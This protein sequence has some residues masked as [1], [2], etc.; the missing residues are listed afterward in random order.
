MGTAARF[1]DGST[2]RLTTDECQLSSARRS[3]PDRQLT[4]NLGRS[5]R[6]HE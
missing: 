6:G 4:A 5:G 2:P 3:E 1:S